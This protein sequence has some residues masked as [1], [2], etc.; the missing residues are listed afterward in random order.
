MKT[1][2][3][4]IAMTSLLLAAALALGGC[5]SFQLQ[6]PSRFLVVEHEGNTLKA[7]TPDESKIQV[8]DFADDTFGS[9]AFWQEALTGDL[10]KSRGY[11]LVSE[12]PV[13]DGD[14][15]AGVSFVLET[16]LSGRVVREFMA[17]FVVPGTWANTIRVLEFVADK[18]AF[19]AEVDG[20]KAA[21]K[22]LR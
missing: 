22:T 18:D 9:L 4:S 8:R 14:G 21:L 2:S 7:L 3:T 6:V 15:R 5:V 12:A 10:V 16:T 1:R 19:D 17:V 20:V 13:V 11:R